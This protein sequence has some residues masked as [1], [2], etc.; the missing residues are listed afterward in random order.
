MKSV[1]NQ[2]IKLGSIELKNRV[3]MAPLTRMRANAKLE[4]S[5][6][7]E[8]YYSQ[9]ASAGLIITEASQISKQGQGYPRTP[10]IYSDEQVK[11]WR[12]V[13]DSVHKNGGKIVLQLWHVGRV[14]HSSYQP[15]ESL[16]VAPSPLPPTGKALLQDFNPTDYEIPHELTEDE[17]NAIL[18]DY[19]TAAKNAKEA[20][21]DGVEVHGANGYL[22]E[23][24]LRSISNHR[25]DQYGG[26]FAN[27]SRFLFEVLDRVIEIWGSDK[28]GLRLSPFSAVNTEL[29]PLAKGHLEYLL[30]KLSEYKLAYLHIT[31]PHEPIV[32][33]EG[34]EEG[35][36]WSTKLINFCRALYQGSLI[37]AGGFDKESAE[38]AIEEDDTDAIAFGR[39][40]ISNPDLPERLFL[41]SELNAYDRST[42]Y[43]GNEIGYTDYPSLHN[44]K[45]L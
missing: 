29:D 20:G 8:T 26:N 44:T 31:R 22:I 11:A 3:V 15:H 34:L 7:H 1:L 43:G 40:F 17:I 27:R 6:L 41:G 38:K 37:A 35:I 14:S 4:P 28:V 24:F 39:N 42:F 12:K 25:T 30:P 33:I 9:R 21:F 2:N 19:S 18:N 36:D 23:Q 5:A 32:G 10:G 16:P 45:A 13:C